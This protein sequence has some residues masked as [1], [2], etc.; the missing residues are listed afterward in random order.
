MGH[1]A[2]SG[3]I[4]AASSDGQTPDGPVEG[5]SI[6]HSTPGEWINTPETQYAGAAGGERISF[7]IDPETGA[8]R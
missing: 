3:S 8:F 2:E 5:G 7:A 1:L 6:I 4:G